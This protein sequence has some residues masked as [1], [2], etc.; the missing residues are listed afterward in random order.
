MISVIQE[1]SRCCL[2][3]RLGDVPNSVAPWKTTKEYARYKFLMNN[4]KRLLL[5]TEQSPGHHNILL[6][7]VGVVRHII[8]H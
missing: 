6:L 5:R 4:V 3:R 7:N 8:S 1:P 2:R